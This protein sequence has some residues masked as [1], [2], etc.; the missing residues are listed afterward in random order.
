MYLMPPDCT[1]KMTRMVNLMVYIFD[2]NKKGKKKPR[3]SKIT[4]KKRKKE[5]ILPQKCEFEK[6]RNCHF[7]E[8]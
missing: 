8:G 2:H 5:N 4:K 6:K 7:I 3:P 1:P